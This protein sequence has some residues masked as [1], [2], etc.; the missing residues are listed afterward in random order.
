MAEF[1]LTGSNRYLQPG[2]FTTYDLVLF[3]GTDGDDTLF[4][5]GGEGSSHFM[6]TPGDD[7]Y[8]LAD[9]PGTTSWSGAVID[10]S[11][12]EAAVRVELG[13]PGGTRTFV[14]AHGT[15]RTVEIFGVAEDGFGGVDLFAG[16]PASFVTGP[17]V[18]GVMGSRFADV[19]VTTW[20]AWG[21]AGDDHLT[22]MSLM[23]EEGNDR[24]FGTAGADGLAGG[25]GNDRVFGRAGDDWVYGDAGKDFVCG[26]K[27]DDF[28]EGGVGRDLLVSGA[29]ND[30]INPDSWEFGYGEIPPTDRARD[31]IR[32]TRADVGDYTDVVLS[33]AFEAGLDEIRFGDA[34]CGA[35]FRVY[36]EE[37][38]FADDGALLRSDDLEDRVNTVLQI[39]AD[40][41]GFDV[42]LGSRRMPDRD[43][44]FLVVVDADLALDHGAWLLT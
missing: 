24:L 28:V 17:A 4:A 11:D 40:G 21:G 19:I 44:Y 7:L 13:K 35:R 27:G 36:Q 23:G 9:H 10:Y 38:S 37:Q 42:S 5:G 26:G 3:T 31:V 14:D 2:A 8:G 18:D 43:D 32:V 12:A 41:D 6:A 33:R 25:V 30:T 15:T 34:A 20:A 22:G 16:H 39:D 29:G 1:V